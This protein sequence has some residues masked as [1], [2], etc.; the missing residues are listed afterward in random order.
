MLRGRGPFTPLPGPTLLTERLAAFPSSSL[1]LNQP[2]T[3]Y[4]SREQIPFVVA[5]D[6]DDAAFTLGMIHAHLR[7]GQMEIMRRVA[8][9]R[10]AQMLGPLCRT[11]DRTLQLLDLPRAS[12]AMQLVMPPGTRRWLDYFVEGVNLYR[13]RIPRLPQEFPV[14]G[15]DLGEP[16]Q[17]E[18]LTAMARLLGA[19][20]N[21]LAFFRL[22]PLLDRPDWGAIWERLLTLSVDDSESF[23]LLREGHPISRVLGTTE[24]ARTRLLARVLLGFGRAGSNAMALA[25]SRSASGGALLA[26]DP[27]LGLSLPNPWLVAGLNCPSF[28][29]VG[30]MAPGL[31]VFPHGRNPWIG[32]G[33]THLRAAS[34]QLY[35]ISGLDE[36]KLQTRKTRLRSRWWFDQKASLRESPFGPVIS[37]APGVKVAGGRRVALSWIGHRGSDE[38]TALLQ[39]SRASNF[40]EFRQALQGYALPAQNFL[41]ADAKGNIGEQVATWLPVRPPGL[42]ADL[43]EN[44]ASRTTRWDRLLAADRLPA[45]YNPDQGFLA[46]ANQPPGDVNGMPLGFLFPLPDRLERMHHQLAGLDNARVEDLMDLQRDVY[47]LRAVQLREAL[48]SRLRTEGLVDDPLVVVLRDWDGCYHADSA[49]A[50]AYQALLGRLLP[51]V[52]KQLGRGREARDV[53]LASHGERF[54]ADALARLDRPSFLALWRDARRHAWQLMN[55]YRVWGN[56][57]RY[58]VQHLFGHLPLLGRRYRFQDLPAPGAAQTLHQSLSPPLTGRPVDVYHGAQARHVSDMADPDANYF[59][60]FGGQDGWLGSECFSDQVALWQRGEYVQVP[61]SEA[62]AAERF[63]VRMVLKPR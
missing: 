22:L 15:I 56:A 51:G 46:S 18:D 62:G 45:R 57:H 58:R 32:W 33:G 54:L 61:L 9:G 35:D 29:V 11:L 19:D 26:C 30:M 4:W 20:V 6:D 7:L 59:V 36:K 52:Y 16:W 8:R 17:L 5:G 12:D 60:L 49:G 53:R 10:T 39:V 38:F 28:Q 50:L 44:P 2:V 13:K 34:S 21:W 25:G 40:A 43:L 14:L 63:A 41:Y 47:S 27:H 24:P 3:V 55:H 1:P 48:L 31:P 42:P 37:D 23:N